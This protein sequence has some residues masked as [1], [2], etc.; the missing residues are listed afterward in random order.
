MTSY[1][2]VLQ[3]WLQ[4][5]LVVFTYD[6]LMVFYQESIKKVETSKHVVP[7]TRQDRAL[8]V[9]EEFQKS[10]KNSRP[11]SKWATEVLGNLERKYEY[12]SKIVQE[13]IQVYA[14]EC[15]FEKTRSYEHFQPAAFTVKMQYWFDTCLALLIDRLVENPSIIDYFAPPEKRMSNMTIFRTLMEDCIIRSIR[16][17]IKLENIVS[18]PFGK[19]IVGSKDRPIQDQKILQ[20]IGRENQELKQ[21]IAKQEKYL[22]SF[23]VKLKQQQALDAQR[24]E[25]LRYLKDQILALRKESEI[26]EKD[27]I[28]AL[29]KDSEQRENARP[30]KHPQPFVLEPIRFTQDEKEDD[31]PRKLNT[32]KRID[33]SPLAHVQDQ[34][35]EDEDEEEEILERA[36]N[37]EVRE[38]DPASDDDQDNFTVLS[39]DAQAASQIT[40]IVQPQRNKVQSLDEKESA[41]KAE[42]K[43]DLSSKQTMD[44][45]SELAQKTPVQ[46]S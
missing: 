38:Q 33:P 5:Q 8:R 28:L 35:Q 41:E 20:E 13:C 4:E 27:H 21:T 34:E 14:R 19:S 29:R 40:K 12:I 10:L 26:R 46:K 17:S 16:S 24:D 18:V 37:L 43:Q 9:S 23:I 45:M 7:P 22:Q 42:S 15:I 30:R 6:E 32:S 3:V 36:R 2:S 25:E 44:L 31:T 39:D 11:P 1:I